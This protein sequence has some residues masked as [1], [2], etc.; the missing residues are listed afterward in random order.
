MFKK[1]ALKCDFVD[2]VTK[3]IIEN[4]KCILNLPIIISYNIIVFIPNTEIIWV[5]YFADRKE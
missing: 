1:S 4:G 3:M 5:K 2:I